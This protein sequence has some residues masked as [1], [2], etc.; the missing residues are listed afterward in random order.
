M[1]YVI[2]FHVNDKFKCLR[3]VFNPIFRRKKLWETRTLKRPN[4]RGVEAELGERERSV[5]GRWKN[6]N[7]S[8]KVRSGE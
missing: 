7:A 5:L 8:L 1:Q 6:I 2:K 3:I 4:W